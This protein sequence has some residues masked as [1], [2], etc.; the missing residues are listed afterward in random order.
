MPP[1]APVQPWAVPG[2][3][4]TG[5]EPAMAAE[6]LRHA[7]SGCRQGIEM[8]SVRQHDHAPLLRFLMLVTAGSPDGGCFVLRSPA[9][10]NSN[11]G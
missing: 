2:G 8:V 5:F 9:K 3:L 7:G 1:R 6:K 10:G 4:A 11:P